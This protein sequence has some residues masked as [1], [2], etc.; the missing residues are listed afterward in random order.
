[1]T[2]VDIDT[3]PF[4]A[5]VITQSTTMF[6]LAQCVWYRDPAVAPQPLPSSVTPSMRS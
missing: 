5:T 3:L 2:V 1:M 4:F 6:I